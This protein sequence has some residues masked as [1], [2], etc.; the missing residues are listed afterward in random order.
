MRNTQ[1]FGSRLATPLSNFPTSRMRA[2]INSLNSL[3]A[4]SKRGLFTAKTFSSKK[5]ADENKRSF[6]G[7]SSVQKALNKA[8]DR[9][10]DERRYA[11]IL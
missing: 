8:F 2:P 9:K 3:F 10:N 4:S 1:S 6:G 5:F 11:S 7:L